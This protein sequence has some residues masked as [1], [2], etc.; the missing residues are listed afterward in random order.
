MRYIVAT[1]SLFLVAAAA[2]GIPLTASWVEGKV[3]YGSGSTWKPV[4]IGD[5]VDSSMS[6][7]LA[8]GAMAEFSEGSRRISLSS[9]GIYSLDA[10]VKAGAEQAKK[11]SGAM[12]KLGKLVDP[13]AADQATAIAGV[14]GAAQDE[15]ET[16][17]MTE[18]EGGEALAEE[19]RS[20][21]REGRFA[22]AATLFGQAAA[23]SEGDEADGYLYAM[24]W[25]L[26]AGGSTIEAIKTLRNFAPEGAEWRAQ[27]GLLLARLDL[28][29]GSAAEARTLLEAILAE[30]FLTGEDLE[31]AKEMLAEAKAVK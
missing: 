11:R 31:L 12:G 29:S 17:W 14:R 7:R 19:A 16:M 1:L 28:D 15:S 8:A 5:K 25:S 22:D 27:R 26:A 9:P 24:S 13:K 23:A 4:N 21:A 30:G 18:D 2:F 6:V 3:E 10:L 20:Y